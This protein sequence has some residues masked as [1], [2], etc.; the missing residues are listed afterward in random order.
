MS[1]AHCACWCVQLC[2]CIARHCP[3]SASHVARLGS[4]RPF[5]VKCARPAAYCGVVPHARRC[6][7]AYLRAACCGVCGAWAH[8]DCV[9]V[10]GVG[11]GAVLL[12]VTACVCVWLDWPQWLCSARC[13]VFS[14]WLRVW[15]CYWRRR[16]VAL[17]VWVSDLVGCAY[18]GCVGR[19]PAARVRLWCDCVCSCM[20]LLCCAK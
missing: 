11:H 5:I 12:Y 13:F 8:C 6:V 10:C 1:C 17:A 7:V 15:Q 9:S 16:G 2:A 20:H 14:A 18:R 3:A 4:T 19:D